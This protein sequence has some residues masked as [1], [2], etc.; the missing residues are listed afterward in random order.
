MFYFEQLLQTAL[1]GVDGTGI[2]DDSISEV[3]VNG[4]SKVFVERDGFLQEVPDVSLGETSL[5]VAVKNIAQ[6]LGADISESKPI[7]YSCLPDG[8]RVAAM[9]PPWSQN[10]VTLT[11]S[12]FKVKPLEIADLIRGGALNPTLAKRLEEYVIGR[13]NILIS[14][15]SGAGK[16]TVLSG[17]ARFI[18]DD[19]R[20]VVVEDAAEVRLGQTNVLCFERNQRQ[21]G[22][23]AVTIRDL[24]EA[25]VAHRPDR[26]IVGVLHGAEAF[27]LLEVWNKGHS[28]TLATIDADG[29]LQA[30]FDLFDYCAVYLGRGPTHGESRP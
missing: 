15:G 7:L 6:C 26:I 8:S 18:P 5:E 2:L 16:T 21:N 29:A 9:I 13:K 24:L 17:L 19:E 12:K 4:S 22:R 28:G 20:I 3:M 14:G 23:H 11:I 25:A 1:I 10:G 27:D 30:V